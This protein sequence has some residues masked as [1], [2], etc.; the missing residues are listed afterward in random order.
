MAASH[1]FMVQRGLHMHTYIHVYRCTRNS[2]PREGANSVGPDRTGLDWTSL[3]LG[4]EWTNFMQSS[5]LCGPERTDPDQTKL[6]RI[7]PDRTR[8]DRTGPDRTGPDWTGPD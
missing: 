5:R 7:G 6:A 8:P 4:A 3:R 2:C 1:Q